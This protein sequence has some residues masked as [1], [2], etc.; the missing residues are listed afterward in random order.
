MILPIG[1]LQQM[2]NQAVQLSSKSTKEMEAY[3]V[4]ISNSPVQTRRLISLEST[5]IQQE[6]FC[7]LPAGVSGE[8]NINDF[9]QRI[10][11]SPLKVCGSLFSVSSQAAFLKQHKLFSIWKKKNGFIF[12]MTEQIE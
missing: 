10:S 2:A 1:M 12:K 3:P 5:C 8:I 4:Y 6:Q 9:S 7:S 11:S